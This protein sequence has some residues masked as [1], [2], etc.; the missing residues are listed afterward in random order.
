MTM[1]A[2]NTPSHPWTVKT[3]NNWL[4]ILLGL[5]SEMML[6]S[7]IWM[8]KVSI[9]SLLYIIDDELST[10]ATHQM[11]ETDGAHGMLIVFSLYCC[12]LISYLMHIGH[13]TSTAR[14]HANVK[15]RTP[16]GKL[17]SLNAFMHT[18]HI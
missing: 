13:S 8:V 9:S 17:I 4:K 16:S 6:Q 15:Y 7:M 18:A 5:A 14:S 10:A 2:V 1:Q 11:S 12:F 3:T